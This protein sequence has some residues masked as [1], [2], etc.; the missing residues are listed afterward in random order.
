MET[1]AA[2][3]TEAPEGMAQFQ[4]AGIQ[5]PGALIGRIGEN[6]QVFVVDA[7]YNGTSAGGGR[8]GDAM[9]RLHH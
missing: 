1:A 9:P 5:A 2:T 8:R 4:Q 6:G 3:S 7:N